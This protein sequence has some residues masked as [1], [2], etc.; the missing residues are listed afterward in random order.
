MGKLSK[1]SSN[2]DQL[3]VNTIRVLSAEGVEKA[4][5]GHPGMPMGMADV[6]YV[7]WTKYLKFNPQD[8]N[9]INRDRFVLSAGHGS[10]LLYS[11][12]Y[13]SGYDVK[14]DDLKSFRQLN[15]RT[16]GHPEVHCL[17][18]V[19][20]TTG[21]LGQ[22]FANGIGMAIGAK[23]LAARFNTGDF[24]IFG[25]HYVYAIVSDGDLMEGISH[26]AA[27]YAGFLGLDNLIYFYD[28]NEIT[29]EGQTNLTYGDDAAKRF[30]AYGWH[31]QTIDG[32]DHKQIEEAIEKAQAEKQ[33]PSIIITKTTIGY[34]SPNKANTAG[35]HGAALGA[36]ELQKTKE[37]LEWNYE[38]EFYVPDEVKELFDKNAKELK[39]KYDEWMDKF[40]AWKAKNP[41]LADQYKNYMEGILPE[42]LDEILVTEDLEKENA[43]RKYSQSVIQKMA[44]A[45]P[46]VVGGSADLAPST[47]TL[48]KNSESIAKNKFEGRNFHFGI[49]E[50]GMGGILN[51]LALYGGFVPF[52]ATFMVFSDYMRPSIRLAALSELQVIYVFTHDSIFLGEDGP[53]HQPVEHLSALRAIPNLNIIRPADGI[54]TA[55]AWAQALKHK[56]GPSAIVL[57]RQKL[58]KIERN[59][60]FNFADAQK[61]GY[62]VYKEKSGK[63]ELVILSSGSEVYLCVNAAKEL[64]KDFSVRVVS[65]PSLTTLQ[66]QDTAYIN[67]LIPQDAKVAVVEAAITQGWGDF[68]R[69]ELYRIDL[70]YFGK[71]APFKDLMKEYGFTAENIVNELSDWLKK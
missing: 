61:G 68:V 52:G 45:V 15:S 62:T 65:V 66:K 30:E 47:N 3:A 6:S 32:T 23:L 33:K 34:G 44:E 20:T 49:R 16:P 38:E 42:N 53:T 69:Q 64:E 43:S 67:E 63:P 5:S 9:W 40:N 36:E 25:K 37:N 4:A 29:I 39:K 21:P 51:G 28:D 13:L 58:G 2:L 24:D 11:L 19:E 50:H 46:F 59:V 14:L 18:G 70:D 54:E 12:L 60:D 41:E 7:L 35:V 10:M 27:S 26:E 1:N 17:P 71:S 22:G 55:S 8:P 56:T 57:T 31:V 48:I